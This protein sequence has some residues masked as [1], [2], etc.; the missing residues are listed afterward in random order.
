MPDIIDVDW[1]CCD[2][3]GESFEH[4]A[5]PD[6]VAEGLL[7]DEPVLVRYPNGRIADGNRIVVTERGLEALKSFVIEESKGSH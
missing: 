1:E 2:A 7:I 4:H 3:E 5:E 6:K